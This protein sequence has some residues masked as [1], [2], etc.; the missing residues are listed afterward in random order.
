MPAM[1]YL[2]TLCVKGYIERLRQGVY[3]KVTRRINN[4]IRLTA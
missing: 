2:R 3:H 4:K 1:G